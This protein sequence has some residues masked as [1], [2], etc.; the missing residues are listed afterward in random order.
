MGEALLIG[1]AEC[2]SEKTGKLNNKRFG[3]WCQSNGFGSINTT[4]RTNAVWLAEEW[5]KVAAVLGQT[6]DTANDPTTVRK[7]YRKATALDEE[8]AVKAMKFYRMADSDSASQA[9]PALKQAI[10]KDFLCR[11]VRPPY[12]GTSVFLGEYREPLT[13]SQ[14]RQILAF[15]QRPSQH[16]REF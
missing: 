2:L 12:C 13:H 8:T 11:L 7:A 4:T 9:V 5:E 6:Q 1:R 15:P 3:E 10:F 16:L 14:G